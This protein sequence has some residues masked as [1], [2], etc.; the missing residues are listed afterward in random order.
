[1]R[2]LKDGDVV[3]WISNNDHRRD[4]YVLSNCRYSDDGS[5][6]RADFM[7]FESKEMYRGC[8]YRTE[9]L[10]GIFE[11]DEFLTAVHG[12]KLWNTT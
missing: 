11:I 9:K 10:A 7:S 12:V 8:T 4:K 5:I 6:L 3:T 1:M 2:K